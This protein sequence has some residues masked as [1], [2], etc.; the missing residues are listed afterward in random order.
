MSSIIN[1]SGGLTQ[2]ASLESSYILR[3][4]LPLDFNFKNLTQKRAFLKDGDIIVIS[5][6]NEEITV[7]GAVNNPSKSFFNKS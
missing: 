2:Y 3:D 1:K 5:S 4:S 6:K 7:S